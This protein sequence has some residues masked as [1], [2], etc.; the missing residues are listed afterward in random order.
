MA[1]ATVLGPMVQYNP[2]SLVE[3]G[4]EAFVLSRFDHCSV[5]SLTATRYVQKLG[6]PPVGFRRTGK[7]YIFYANRPLRNNR[8]TGVLLAFNRRWFVREALNKI[9]FPMDATIQGMSWS[10]APEGQRQSLWQTST[11]GSGKHWSMAL[12]LLLSALSM[13]CK[14]LKWRAGRVL[15]SRNF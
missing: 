6:Q 9:A 5:V 15:L 3:D 14:E 12:L 11:A 13:D 7:W 1:C 2:C 10:G 4:R 8:H